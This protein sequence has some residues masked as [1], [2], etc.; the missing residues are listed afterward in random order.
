MIEQSCSPAVLPKMNSHFNPSRRST[1]FLS[2]SVAL[3]S[4][5]L[6]WS[7]LRFTLDPF[8]SKIAYTAPNVTNPRTGVSYRGTIADGVEH[9][10]N[11]FYAED[12]SGLNRFA[13]PVPYTPP[14]GSIVD[15]TASGAVCP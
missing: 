12:T 13:P 10:Q 11:I 7:W 14:S 1:I 4:L 6:N 8:G 3:L 5:L 15:A 9:F 2:A